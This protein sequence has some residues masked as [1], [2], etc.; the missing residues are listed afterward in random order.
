ME[1]TT[2]PWWL[3]DPQGGWWLCQP[4]KKRRKHTFLFSLQFLGL[5]PW[6]FCSSAVLTNHLA[7]LSNDLSLFQ[8]HINH[9]GRYLTPVF[10]VKCQNVDFLIT[11]PDMARGSIGPGNWVD[12][13]INSINLI[14]PG[15]WDGQGIKLIGQSRGHINPIGSPKMWKKKKRKMFNSIRQSFCAQLFFVWNPGFEPW[16]HAWKSTTLLLSYFAS[17]WWVDIRSDHFHCT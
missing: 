17:T 13:L 9:S 3:G 10:L 14:W 4:K 11:W 2:P 7:T 1:V 15:D 16:S 8:V 12:W 6:S 5:K